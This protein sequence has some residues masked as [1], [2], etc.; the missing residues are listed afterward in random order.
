MGGQEFLKTH[1][2]GGVMG[3]QFWGGGGVSESEKKKKKKK[4]HSDRGDIL[5]LLAE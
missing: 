4:G 2:A 3:Q 5:P 1:V